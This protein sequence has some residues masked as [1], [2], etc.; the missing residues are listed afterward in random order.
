[1]AIEMEKY[2]PNDE[3]SSQIVVMHR[4]CPSE[5]GEAVLASL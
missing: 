2:L 4:K 3:T 1:M 5:Y